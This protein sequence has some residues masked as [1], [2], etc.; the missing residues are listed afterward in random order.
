MATRPVSSERWHEA[1]TAEREYWRWPAID[2]REFVNVLAGL[3]DS[4]VWLKEHLPDSPPRG[5]WLEVGIGPLGIGCLHFLPDVEDGRLV[6]VDPLEPLDESEF[7]LPTPLL[8]A[9]T[10]ARSR[11]EQR[12]A[13]G[14]ATGLPS[15]SFALVSIHNVLDHVRDPAAVLRE[16]ERVLLPEGIVFIGCD[17]HS[18]L[19]EFRHRLY[20]K[21]R[22]AD[23]L[24]IRAHPFR[25]RPGG[26]FGLVE[27]CGLSVLAHNLSN[28]AIVSTVGRS[29][30]LL[31]LATPSSGNSSIG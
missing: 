25:F 29:M 20:L 9:V 15:S 22:Y 18:W 10:S 13:S 5:D 26:L 4:A 27:A 16:T 28:R 24:F 21:S 1:Q 30:R 8:A 12:V 14:E 31:I 19:H 2:P 17:V 23:A 11:Y 3:A 7:I 6:G